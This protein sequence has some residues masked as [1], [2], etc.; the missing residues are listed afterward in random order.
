MGRLD[1][2]GLTSK[3]ACLLLL[4]LVAAD[5][6]TVCAEAGGGKPRPYGPERSSGAMAFSSSAYDCFP[7]STRVFLPSFP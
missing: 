2:G 3:F 5:A 6:G 4:S 7:D 1:H